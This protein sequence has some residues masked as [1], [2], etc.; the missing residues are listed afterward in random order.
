MTHYSLTF[1]MTDSLKIEIWTR[2]KT[3]CDTAIQQVE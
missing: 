1:Q 3:L 2:A